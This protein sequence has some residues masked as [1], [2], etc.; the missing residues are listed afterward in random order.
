MGLL[1]PAF[2]IILI[3]FVSGIPVAEGLGD[4]RWRRLVAYNQ[5]KL[6]TS[7][8]IP[9]PPRVYATLPLTIKYWCFH[10]RHSPIMHKPVKR[11]KYRADGDAAA[12]H[13]SSPLI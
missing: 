12:E 8:L 13:A 5:Y 1:S 11:R 10:E 4:K 9:L 3:V 7:P 6:I 2:T